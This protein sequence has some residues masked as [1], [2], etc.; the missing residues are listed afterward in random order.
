M[1]SFLFEFIFELLG[2]I[3][4]IVKFKFYFK[5]IRL[6]RGRVKILLSYLS[7]FIVVLI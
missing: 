6:N 2:I 4:K 7:D 1:S 5:F 3:F